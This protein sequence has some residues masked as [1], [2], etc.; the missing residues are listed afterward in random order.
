VANLTQTEF[1]QKIVFFNHVEVLLYI[2]ELGFLDEACVSQHCMLIIP[3][4]V[5]DL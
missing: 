5:G 4:I 1:N 2:D 3:S